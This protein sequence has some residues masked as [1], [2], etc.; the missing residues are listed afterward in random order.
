MILESII[1][2]G[3]KFKVKW[4]CHEA[5]CKLD[6]AFLPT[7]GF[8][9]QMID[10]DEKKLKHPNKKNEFPLGETWKWARIVN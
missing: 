3:I 5:Y 10:F 2:P 1:S 8:F 9:L 4:G 7:C 6:D